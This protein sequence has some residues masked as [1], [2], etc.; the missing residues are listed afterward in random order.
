MVWLAILK[1]T[2]YALSFKHNFWGG[3]NVLRCFVHKKRS[4]FCLLAGEE[5]G[6][7]FI[8]GHREVHMPLDKLKFPFQLMCKKTRASC[9]NE[10]WDRR[11]IEK[12]NR[13]SLDNFSGHELLIVLQTCSDYR[14]MMLSSF[15]ALA[16]WTFALSYFSRKWGGFEV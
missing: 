8:L 15:W 13:G 12:E 4:R 6:R 7:D 9:F 3:R 2:I 14:K 10:N 5:G 11:G 1:N 16:I